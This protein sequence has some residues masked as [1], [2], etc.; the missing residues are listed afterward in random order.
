[1]LQF[2]YSHKSCLLFCLDSD[3]LPESP[4]ETSVPQS[5]LAPQH[6]PQAETHQEKATNN[7]MS[8]DGTRPLLSSEPNAGLSGEGPAH[9]QS[10]DNGSNSIPGLQLAADKPHDTN[11][12]QHDL[13]PGSLPQVPVKADLTDVDSNINEPAPSPYHHVTPEASYKLVKNVVEA[14]VTQQADIGDKGT[15][16]ES[17]PEQFEERA[18]VPRASKQKE[19]PVLNMD[20][21]ASKPVTLGEEEKQAQPQHPLQES[22]EVVNKSTYS[23]QANVMQTETQTQTKATDQ[24]NISTKDHPPNKQSE[25]PES[26]RK[27]PVSILSDVSRALTPESPTHSKTTDYL[28]QTPPSIES[29][30]AS[31]VEVAVEVKTETSVQARSLSPIDDHRRPFGRYTAWQLPEVT[32]YNYIENIVYTVVI[33]FGH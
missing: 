31:D 11:L 5:Q 8:S 16:N 2:S 21:P 24:T 29:Q 3:K 13:T 17:S 26:D 7:L 15:V 20:I 30:L 25:L 6:K 4:P 1:M 32:L 14:A 9:G 33:K 28:R 23:V 19:E 12:T 27:E 10:P 22:P 18:T